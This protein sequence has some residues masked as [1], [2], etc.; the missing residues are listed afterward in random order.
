MQNKKS[1]IKNAP[2]ELQN[3]QDKMLS[4]VSKKN[5]HLTKLRKAQPLH[6]FNLHGK[7]YKWKNIKEKDEFIP[8][9]ERT[10]LNFMKGL[11]IRNIDIVVVCN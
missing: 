10:K 8:R 3:F 4:T 1:R 6:L 7:E 5:S 9:N 11:K 2:K